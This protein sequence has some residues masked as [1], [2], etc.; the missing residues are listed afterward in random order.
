MDTA[1]QKITVLIPCYNEAHNIAAVIG[2]FPRAEIQTRGYD[3]EIVV[4]DN[5]SS[6]D[7]SIVARDAGA[8]VLLETKKGK[9]NAMKRG[10]RYIQ[11][12]S[13]YVVMLDGD[14]TYRP[15]E[16]LRMVELLSSGFCN[17]VTGSR[18]GGRILE[19]SMS[20][21]NRIGNWVFSH[22]VRLLYRINVTDVLTGYYAW[23]YEALDRM[24]PHLVSD[25]F[26]IEMEMVTK[27]AR[28]GEEVY[29]V[30][31]SYHPRGGHSN[32]RP[33]YDGSRILMML[34]RNLWWS[35]RVILPKRIAFVSDTIAPYM[36][37]GKET[38][39]FEITRRLAASGRDVHVY[40]MQWWEGG[41]AM[42]RDGVHFHAI[43][44]LYPLY[45]EG[46]RSLYEA[47]MFGLAVFKLMFEK[48]DVLDVDQIPFIPLLSARV[49]TWLRGKKMH[50]TWHEVW[51]KKDWQSYL[52]V[53]KGA[54]AFYVERV[55]LAL[56]DIII[57]NSPHTTKRLRAI[58]MSRHVIEVPLGVDVEKI[59]AIAPAPRTS[60][61]VF[62][63]R[64]IAHKHVDVLV[65][66]IALVREM[67]PLISCVIIGE[68]PERASIEEKIKTLRLENA[69]QIV[70]GISNSALY[71]LMKASRMLVL[72]STR[73]G[74]G[75]T[76]LEAHAA[77]I[78]V[79]TTPHINNAAK[80]LIQ[81]GVNG[82]LVEPHPHRIAESIVR[83][84]ESRD[85][86]EPR[87][88]IERFDWRLVLERMELAIG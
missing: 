5:N 3:L 42:E 32:L 10:F 18:L 81:E 86:L 80:D 49:V 51:S 40:T 68:G 6:D 39:L 9:G 85:T 16:L 27:M 50:A 79:I 2:A 44:P 77:G 82:F 59:A 20:M 36:R 67:H 30:P 57:S 53:F 33:F 70:N 83:V 54:L 38:R 65:E 75:L 23:T 61:V 56:P 22:L 63:G 29:S 47:F 66:A 4:I 25:H 37:G 31:I 46:K 58:G 17:A 73:E 14:D 78:P 41:S 88:G 55:C 52:G 15:E 7:T 48:F 21:R 26:A 11:P 8:T 43:A 71:G 12:D 45:I 19:G 24:R 35:P 64:L 34:L 87:I 72:P 62:V 74:F 84:L 13:T 28:L 60:D 69:V 1:K 76:V